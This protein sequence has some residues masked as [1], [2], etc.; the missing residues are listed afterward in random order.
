VKSCDDLKDEN[1]CKLTRDEDTNIFINSLNDECEWVKNSCS[2][3]FGYTCVKRGMVDGCCRYGNGDDCNDG[4]TG[5]SGVRAHGCIWREEDGVGSC[6]DF[7]C[8]DYL[9]NGGEN[10]CLENIKNVSGGC[11]VSKL[12]DSSDISCENIND[13]W[14]CDDLKDRINCI[15][16]K[17]DK[18]KF[19]GLSCEWVRMNNEGKCVDELKVNDCGIFSVNDDCNRGTFYKDGEY[20][21]ILLSFIMIEKS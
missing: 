18:N 15:S 12:D 16:T 6:D 21:G 5:S 14:S 13:I 20:G 1:N 19:R 4:I 3:S 17:D 10:S 9:K 7:K 2:G 11:F 8:E